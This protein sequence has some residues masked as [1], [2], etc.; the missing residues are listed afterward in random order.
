MSRL[1]KLP[2]RVPRISLL[3]GESMAHFRENEPINL[4]GNLFVLDESSMYR[5]ESDSTA[6]K[7]IY[8]GVNWKDEDIF[9]Q[10]AYMVS[11]GNSIC[12]TCDNETIWQ[13]RP[14][15]E[16]AVCAIT[17]EDFLEKLQEFGL[18]KGKEFQKYC[19]SE[20]IH[21]QERIYF[22]LRDA[23]GDPIDGK[24]CLLS[25]PVSDLSKIQNESALT[26]YLNAWE[27][28]A[29]SEVTVSNDVVMQAMYVYKPDRIAG[30]VDDRLILESIRMSDS[31]LVHR[32]YCVAYDIASN[33]VLERSGIRKVIR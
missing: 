21:Y 17:N 33:Q 9:Y 32:E 4:D 29:D 10:D 11:D 7:Q 8:T 3:P 31:S 16:Q 28:G 23:K 25:A 27:T 20:L 2:E 13:Y 6:V 18:K 5:L 24:M 19:I 15:E 30:I 12:F 22:L 14:G 26:D 1:L